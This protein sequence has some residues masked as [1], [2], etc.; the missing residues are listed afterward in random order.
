M[1]DLEHALI[2]ERMTRKDLQNNYDLLSKDERLRLFLRAR[3][4]GNDQEAQAITDA[5]PRL[6]QKVIDFSPDLRAL[7]TTTVIPV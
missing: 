5:S 6:D 3:S 2:A 1:A 4:R 7:M